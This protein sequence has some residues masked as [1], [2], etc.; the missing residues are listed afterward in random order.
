M[1]RYIPQKSTENTPT[2]TRRP[3]SRHSGGPISNKRAPIKPNQQRVPVPPKRPRHFSD[4]D[5]QLAAADLP[6]VSDLT[7]VSDLPPVSELT[8]ASDL[9]AIAGRV[10]Q[11]LRADWQRISAL[12]ERFEAHLDEHFA[13]EDDTEEQQPLADQL[14]EIKEDIRQ[15]LSDELLACASVEAFELA[16]TAHLA[17]ETHMHQRID[18]LEASAERQQQQLNQQVQALETASASY[19]DAADVAALKAQADLMQPQAAYQQDHQALEQRL[20]ALSSQM[21][22]LS[23]SLAGL[24]SCQCPAGAH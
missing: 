18:E 6:P 11:A 21:Q 23:S 17:A 7:P 13:Q 15:Q 12:E 5:P 24:K 8:A 1:Y 19:A 20:A 16:Q 10:R 14:A 4:T 2:N 22:T 3:I 9:N